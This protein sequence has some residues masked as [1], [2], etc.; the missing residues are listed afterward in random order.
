M[1]IFFPI[2]T[3]GEQSKNRNSSHVLATH[4]KPDT[5]TLMAA[6]AKYLL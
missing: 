5:A 6:I 2:A 1:I 4:F 3:Y